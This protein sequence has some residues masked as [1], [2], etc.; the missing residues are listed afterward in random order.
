MVAYLSP[1]V[2]V[3]EVKSG[4]SPIA[5]VGTSTAGFI[6]VINSGTGTTSTQTTTI[7]SSNAPVSLN[8]TSGN[9]LTGT[10]TKKSFT[11]V[12]NEGETFVADEGSYNFY[13]TIEGED[14]EAVVTE[15]PKV[16]TT[17]STVDVKL[18]TGEGSA[19]PN[20]A[21]IKVT[22]QVQ[23]SVINSDNTYTIPGEQGETDFTSQA[24]GEVVLCT[25]FTEFKNAFGDFSQLTG[26]SILAHAVYGF[27]RNGGTRCYVVW[28]ATKADI[29]SALESFEAIDEIALV[30]APG[31]TESDYLSMII[32]HCGQTTQDRF[33]ILDSTEE[34]DITTLRPGENGLPGTSNYSAYYFPWIQV[35]DPATNARKYVPPSGHI[36][37]VY[38]RVDTNRGVHKAPANETV[39]GALGLKYNISKRKQDGLNPQGVN[40]IRSLNGNILVW[41]ARTWGGD[42]N[43]EFKYINIRRLFNFIRESIDEGTQ[44]TVFE[45][46]TPELWARIRRNVTAFLTTVWQSGALF[47]ATPEQAFYVKCDEENNPPNVRELGQVV[48]EIGI[49]V[50]KPA[51]FVI[52]RISQWNQ[53]DS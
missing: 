46:N 38:A 26:Q 25:N 21:P 24:A 14:T 23:T 36:A 39:L 1:G 31:V 16:G 13:Y 52:F 22:Y 9:I 27:F 7:G 8:D 43:G 28:V 45:P 18:E 34:A 17:A 2:Y 53:S 33:A 19:I 29:E 5:G 20:N 51:E 3:E 40:C 12:I 11:F 42:S 44:W 37:G 15:A 10:G 6:G 48:I 30:A 35:Y 47:G 4:V 41:G 49:A 32:N 50:V